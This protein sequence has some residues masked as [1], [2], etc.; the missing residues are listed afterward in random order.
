MVLYSEVDSLQP[1]LRWEPFPRPRDQKPKNEKLLSQIR[2]VTYD[3]KI[4]Q[5]M[6]DYPARLVCDV[7]GLP[8]P[9]YHLPY[10]LKH[11]TKYFWTF[12]ARYTLRGQPQVTRWAFSLAPAIAEGM[13]PGGTCDL[14]EIP[15]TNYYR[16]TTP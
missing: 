3:L 15:S 14:D 11:N 5:A 4:W 13:G 10:P 16:F 2:D 6:N 9:Q 8:E 7:T 12:R 1:T